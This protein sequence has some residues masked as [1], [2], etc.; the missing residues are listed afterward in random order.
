MSI[1]KMKYLIFLALFFSAHSS[2][3]IIGPEQI[4][5]KLVDGFEINTKE[6]ELCD[7]CLMVHVKAPDQYKSK[8]F[9]HG[10]FTVKLNG[11]LISKTLHSSVN[12]A[13]LPEFIGV[14]GSK[15]DI[16]Y[17]VTFEYGEG[18]CMSYMLVHKSTSNG[19]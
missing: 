2:A 7:S 13:G 18:H 14:V 8:P 1:K 3:C 9:S 5:A 6:S 11:K 10:V 12:D 16:E 17:E 15:N 4:S 19:S